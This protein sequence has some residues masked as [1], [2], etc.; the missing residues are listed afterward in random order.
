MPL[1]PAAL[2]KG[3]FLMLDSAHYVTIRDKAD[4]QLQVWKMAAKKDPNLKT[5]ETWQNRAKGYL[6]DISTSTDFE[7]RYFET[8]ETLT[9]MQAYRGWALLAL[10]LACYQANNCEHWGYCLRAASESMGYDPRHVTMWF[11]QEWST[12]QDA[13]NMPT[14]TPQA[15]PTPASEAVSVFA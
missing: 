11:N 15:P 6:I 3:D 14:E 5:L 9:G 4:S 12:R 8:L 2:I 10:A 1:V 13:Q 7:S